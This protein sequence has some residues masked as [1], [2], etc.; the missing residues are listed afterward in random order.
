MSEAAKKNTVVVSLFATDAD[1]GDNAEISYYI[2]KG[3]SFSH[4]FIRRTGEISVNKELDRERISEYDLEVSATDG[5]HVA[6][7][8][9]IVTGDDDCD[10][11]DDGDDVD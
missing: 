3:D 1:T 8:R 11:D 6:F 4:F 5:A 10:V 9:V 2:T 7:C